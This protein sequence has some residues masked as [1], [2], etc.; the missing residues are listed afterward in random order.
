MAIKTVQSK[1]DE[2]TF[3]P[4]LMKLAKGIKVEGVPHDTDVFHARYSDADFAERMRDGIAKLYGTE[5]L[6]EIR[7]AY[8]LTASPSDDVCYSRNFEHWGKGLLLKR[9]D[10]ETIVKWYD[11]STKKHRFANDRREAQPIAPACKGEGVAK[12]CGC[13]LTGRLRVILP[14]LV[15]AARVPRGYIEIE[16]T[17]WR[18]DA[19]ISACLKYIDSEFAKQHNVAL[20]AIPLIIY[21]HAVPRVLT[22]GKKKLEHVIRVSVDEE[23]WQALLKKKS[24]AV[25]QQEQPY[26][27]QLDALDD[28]AA[29][30]NDE[31]LEE[32]DSLDDET[33]LDGE[34]LSVDVRYQSL[35]EHQSEMLRELHRLSV[36]Y[37]G[38]EDIVDWIV[39]VKLACS[40]YLDFFSSHK[41][42]E[43]A[44]YAIARMIAREKIEVLVYGL[45]TLVEGNVTR[46]AL[47]FGFG[48][49]LAYSRDVFRN[50]GFKIGKTSTKFKAEANHNFAETIR[51]DK[52]AMLVIEREKVDEADARKKQRYFEVDALSKVS[53][54]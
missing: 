25:L 15:V 8:L 41:T 11:K 35:N 52:L 45:K 21:R 32:L 17:A 46:Y 4:R 44:K 47:P 36:Q 43:Q 54:S 38:S 20:T 40:N 24:L 33:A 5:T 53:K 6:E 3:L 37:L 19:S 12:D 27:V 14:D 39:L 51:V 29:L 42:I 50:A 1:A 31:L 10:G 13:K 30:D 48:Y 18:D 22:D 28:A 9:C 2:S 49:A 23:A 34:S 7:N 26:S 16:H